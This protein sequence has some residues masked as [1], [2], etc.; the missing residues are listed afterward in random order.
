[1]NLEIIG[2]GDTNFL[3]KVDLTLVQDPMIFL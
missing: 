1:M 2:V 3:V